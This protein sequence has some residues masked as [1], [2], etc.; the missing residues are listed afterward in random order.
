MPDLDDADIHFPLVEPTVIPS[1]ELR[2]FNALDDN[3]QR[4]LMDIIQS[5]S[6][7]KMDL[8]QREVLSYARFFYAFRLFI[9]FFWHLA[10]V[11]EAS[12]LDG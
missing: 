7:A 3:T 1:G 11:G 9:K 6:F 5:G 8:Y 2:D 4:S 10:F 12:L